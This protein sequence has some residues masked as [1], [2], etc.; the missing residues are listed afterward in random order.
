MSDKRNVWLDGI[1]GVAVGDALGLPVQF[2]ER[3]E[4]ASDPVTEMLP[5]DLYLSPIGTWSDDTSMTMAMYESIKRLGYVDAEDI[6]KNFVRWMYEGAFS[7]NDQCI[8]EGNTCYSSIKNYKDHGDIFTCGR[9]GEYANG[10]GSLM[11]TMPICLYYAEKEKSGDATVEE[12]I[13][14]I[15]LVSALTHNHLRACM[16]CGL[17]FFCVKEMIYGEGDLRTKLQNGMNEG[18]KFY[19]K[20]K[21]NYSELTNYGWFLDLE[22]FAKTPESSI[23]SKGYVVDTFE[24]AIWSLINT[25]T[26]R[27]AMI[28]AVNLGDDTDTV[29]AI[30]GGLAGL[31]YG[32]ETI[33]EEWLS[34]LRKREWIEEMCGGKMAVAGSCD[35]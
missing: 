10:N 31:Y 14:D 33:P 18:F 30:A 4:L 16:A 26:Y 13:K 12:A 20:D 6:M 24:V 17:Y 29:A 22:E 7:A 34:V 3:E 19:G 28:K 15:H 8:D 25:S 35:G 9:T 27:D 21:E 5:C 11:R 2:M 1:M 23:S 32:Y